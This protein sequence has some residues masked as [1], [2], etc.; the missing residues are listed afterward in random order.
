[1]T[2][3]QDTIVDLDDAASLHGLKL[4]QLRRVAGTFG[5]RHDV[6]RGAHRFMRVQVMWRGNVRVC[7][8]IGV[9]AP[10]QVGAVLAAMAPLHESLAALCNPAVVIW[11]GNSPQFRRRT[12]NMIALRVVD[13]VLGQQVDD[14]GALD[15]FGNGLFAKTADHID[16][17][18]HE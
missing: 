6:G 5:G 3:E 15:E 11:V 7:A 9:A 10:N 18:L 13:F 16:Q 17:G 4:A 2:E 14:F 8:P 1:M 12:A